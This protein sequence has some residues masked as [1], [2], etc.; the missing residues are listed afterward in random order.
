MATIIA[1]IVALLSVVTALSLWRR[2]R[3]SL[4]TANARLRITRRERDA[5][6]DSLHDG[7]ALMDS[8]LQGVPGGVIITDAQRQIR[9]I[10]PQA[11]EVFGTPPQ[12]ATGKSLMEVVLDHRISDLVGQCLGASDPVQQEVDYVHGHRTLLLQAL[13]TRD[14]S[15]AV[16]GAVL[17]VQDMTELRRLERV[18][19]EFITNISHEL[20]TP[21]ASIKAL[22]ES[23][24]EGAMAE[25]E[26]G[27][28]FLHRVVVE[29]DHLTQMVD[30]LRMLSHV[31]SGQLK[32][33]R[34]TLAVD[35]L[36]RDAVNRLAAQADR[37]GLHMRVEIPAGV[38]PVL[39]NPEQV[40]QVM[41][42]L[43]DN[44]IKFTPSGG[45]ITVSA[46]RQNG[47]V[48]VRVADTG[49]GISQDDLS[50]IFERLY[51]ADRARASKGTGLGLAIVKHVIQSH[52]GRVWAESELG[53][54]ST[55]C[56][57][58]PVASTG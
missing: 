47:Q 53:R 52:G 46:A 12:G 3:G 4:W 33:E 54:G 2:A 22:V 35:R 14:R 10:S 16:N 42:N 37:K 13:S 39:A 27:R 15:G 56:F 9:Y 57:T 49:A 19:Q 51:K 1:S 11:A 26:I 44:A 40:Q 23:L 30:Q 7:R 17:A 38:P 50:R 20:R 43:L 25:P 21:L 32:L 34:Q 8:L 41:M 6:N 28:D 55:F 24:Q 31:E 5:L 29:V 18:R 45:Q 36:A 48:E 58:L